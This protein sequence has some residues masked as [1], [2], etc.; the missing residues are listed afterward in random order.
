MIHALRQSEE[1]LRG[2]D[3][4]S[5]EKIEELLA[6]VRRESASFQRTNGGG[7]CRTHSGRQVMYKE[8]TVTYGMVY[9]GL[10]IA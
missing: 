9:H 3:L 1:E 2:K 10:H 6:N 4:A 7:F 5:R 8:A